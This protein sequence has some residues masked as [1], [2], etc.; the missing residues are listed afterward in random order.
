[1][2]ELGE[3]IN[4]ASR[5]NHGRSM[6]AAAALAKSRGCE[7]SKSTITNAYRAKLKTI[8]PLV[9]RGIAAGY[10]IPETE[11]ARAMLGDMGF[12]IGEYSPSAESA[13]RRD[14][15]LSVEAR[16]MLLAAIAAARPGRRDI[17]ARDE[18][19]DGSDIAAGF[20]PV[21]KDAG[22]LRDEDRG[23]RHQRG[24]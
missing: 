15:D 8:T 7:I 14:P 19:Q 24:G 23:K 21:P 16:A 5:A 11:V 10:D 6:H 4:T 20:L 3:L 9:I 22:V 13:I 12:A 18:V 1:M 2:T 17:V